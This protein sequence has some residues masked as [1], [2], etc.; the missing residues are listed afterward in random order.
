MDEHRT[1][2]ISTRGVVQGRCLKE[3]RHKN[4]EQH[5]KFKVGQGQVKQ[6]RNCT[7]MFLSIPLSTCSMFLIVNFDDKWMIHFSFILPT[8]YSLT[9]KSILMTCAWNILT[10]TKICKITRSLLYCCTVIKGTFTSFFW[11]TV[12]HQQFATGAITGFGTL[13]EYGGKHWHR[14]GPLQQQNHRR[15]PTLAKYV[16]WYSGS[17]FDL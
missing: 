3:S 15:P 13:R 10:A 4:D 9:F 11:S 7:F 8:P 6:K 17:R 16:P 2:K 5:A 14:W 1:E 12:Y